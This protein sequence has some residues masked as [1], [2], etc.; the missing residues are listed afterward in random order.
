MNYRKTKLSLISNTLFLNFSIFLL[1]F[2][3]VNFYTRD[4]AL[5]L[6][7][8]LI[9]SVI[10]TIF[11]ILFIKNKI[12]K[13]NTLKK[14]KH[15]YEEI[16]NH[17]LF[18]NYI[19]LS[20]TICEIFSITPQSISKNYSHIVSHNC[21][22]YLSFNKE[23]IQ[24]EDIIELLKEY[25][26]NQIKIFC[27]SHKVNLQIE[28]IDIELITLD[29]IIKKMNEINYHIDGIIKIKSKPQIT[30]KYIL[31]I[32]FNK[33]RSK[34]YFWL[35]LLLIFSSLFTPFTIYYTI[36]GSLLIVASIY[37]RF[38]TKFN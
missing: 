26:Y 3:W 27:I 19:N 5:A 31:N 6:F 12:S 11:Y 34:N 35:G 2:I 15:S 1:T 32:S 10:F 14:D 36:F 22:I 20:K 38:N 29:D 17:F 18:S 8:G 16:K 28:N 7:L 37:S 21:D 30:L 23:D 13:E 24:N 33:A 25:R 9:F 4:L